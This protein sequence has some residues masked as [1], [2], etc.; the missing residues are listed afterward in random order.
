MYERVAHDVRRVWRT[1]PFPGAWRA[2]AD[3][4]RK[5]GG[6]RGAARLDEA[7]C[8]TG[9]GGYGGLAT[10]LADTEAGRADGQ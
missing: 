10:I 8:E 2:I 6:T 1:E 7:R 3:F 9:L 5:A 4:T